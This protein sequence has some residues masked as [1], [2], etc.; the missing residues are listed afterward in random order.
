MQSKKQQQVGELVKRNFGMVL[1]EKGANIYNDALVSVTSVIMSS[2]LSLAKIYLSVY[3]TDNK[4]EIIQLLQNETPG[5]KSEL[6]RR[7]R[8]HVRRIPDISL[9]MDDTLDEMYRVDALFDRLYEENQM[10]EQE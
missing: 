6:V 2:D 7:I 4:L 9:Y 10:G 5:L 8:R 3:N 1:L